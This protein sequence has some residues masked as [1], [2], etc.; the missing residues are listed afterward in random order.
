MCEEAT[1]LSTDKRVNTNS[2]M[3][4][5]KRADVLNLGFCTPILFVFHNH[6]ITRSLYKYI[7]LN[8]GNIKFIAYCLL[9]IFEKMR[10]IGVSI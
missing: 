5:K 10:G 9:G 7:F 1:N 3:F 8:L 6:L 2:I 4:A